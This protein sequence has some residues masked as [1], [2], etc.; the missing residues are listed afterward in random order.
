MRVS[1]YVSLNCVCIIKLNNV[2]MLQIN[3]CTICVLI[4]YFLH[5]IKNNYKNNC[6][7]KIIIIFTNKN[8]SRFYLIHIHIYTY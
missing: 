5:K 1:M 6:Y 7:Y 8:Y 4:L 2:M 3:V